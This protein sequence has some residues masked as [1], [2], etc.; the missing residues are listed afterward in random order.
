MLRRLKP[1]HATL[2]SR[3]REEKEYELK[4]KFTGDI[5]PTSR[6]FIQ[7]LNL[8]QRS[9]TSALQ[10]QLV[11]RNFYDANENAIV[12]SISFNFMDSD[13]SS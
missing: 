1:E 6:E 13:Y 10:F 3:D 9:A 5:E 11:G 12:I 8:I 4:F 2:T 7:I